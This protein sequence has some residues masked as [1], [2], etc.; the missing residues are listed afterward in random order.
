MWGS[1]GS[2]SRPRRTSVADPEDSRI[3]EPDDIAREGFVDFFAFARHQQGRAREAHALA[4]AHV[5]R[6]GVLH[7]TAGAD[8]HERD[9]VAMVRI[10]VGLDLE[11]EAREGT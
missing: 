7:E 5:Q 1:P 9:P 2:G 8:A 3:E 10:H 4:G 11:H 6:R